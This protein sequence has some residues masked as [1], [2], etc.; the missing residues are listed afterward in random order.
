MF[1]EEDNFINKTLDTFEATSSVEVG[2][3]TVYD[4]VFTDT[5]VFFD[6]FRTEIDARK[7]DAPAKFVEEQSTGQ[8]S[9]YSTMSLHGF[10]QNL[11]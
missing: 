11:K 10:T 1:D 7:T 3:E 6:Y 9:V 2:N 8:I 5:D 4:L